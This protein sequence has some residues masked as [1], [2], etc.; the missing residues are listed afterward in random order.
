MVTTTGYIIEA[1]C[2]F[3]GIRGDSQI[4]QDLF[5]TPEF[6]NFMESGDI[7][8]FA[9]RG[10][11]G[12]R[13]DFENR[14]ISVN[15]HHNVGKQNQLT[16]RQANESRL[17]TKVRWVIEAINGLLKKSYL[18]KV[19]QNKSLP[20]TGDDVRIACALVNYT[21][22]PLVADVDLVREMKALAK[23]PNPLFN[24]FNG[25]K[26]D[27]KRKIFKYINASDLEEIPGF[28]VITRSF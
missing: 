13:E 8:V 14:G 18:D 26:Y 25:K 3:T 15:L 19:V 11:Y 5:K 20:H 28:S 2:N 6:S 16:V 22:R 23:K 17:V 24:L 10:F 27:A 12:C 9:D 1:W 4:I 7:R 21:Y